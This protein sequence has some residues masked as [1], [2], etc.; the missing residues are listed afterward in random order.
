ML[1]SELEL[2]RLNNYL[3]REHGYFEA[4]Y[5]MWRVVYSE[6][7]FELRKTKFTEEGLELLHE[8]VRKLPKYKQWIHDCYV[9]ERLIPVM[10]FMDT[11]LVD[12]ISYEP[13]WVFRDNQKR[14]LPPNI[15]IIRLIINQVLS[16]AAKSIGAK[17]KN[18]EDDKHDGP[19]VKKLKIQKLKEQ[20]FGDE[21]DTTDALAYREGVV[22]PRNY[23]DGNVN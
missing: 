23:G 14:P 5:P 16:A 11:D 20:L 12:K 13:V 8:E 18:P 3:I 4:T 9:L 17:Y 7:Q 19:E 1:L 22:V 10:D 21:N 15:D 2:D 6:D